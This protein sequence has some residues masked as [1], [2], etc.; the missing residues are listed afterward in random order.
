LA[1]HPDVPLR[2]PKS[3]FPVGQ[4]P[5]FVPISECAEIRLR[6]SASPFCCLFSAAALSAGYFANFS[7]ISDF[8][9]NPEVGSGIPKLALAA[10]QLPRF[11]AIAAAFLRSQKPDFAS[12]FRCYVARL[13][14]PFFLRDI[15]PIFCGF[16]ISRKTSSRFQA[17]PEIGLPLRPVTAI[18]P[19]FGSGPEGAIIRL[20]E[21]VSLLVFGIRSFCWVRRQFFADFG[22][23]AKRP[24]LAAPIGFR[25]LPFPVAQLPRIGPISATFR[26]T[27]K[28]DFAKPFRRFFRGPGRRSFYKEFRQ[29]CADF[30]L[31]AKHP[32]FPFLRVTSPIFR[33]F[34]ISRKTP[35]RSVFPGFPKL[36]FAVAQLPRFGPISASFPRSPKPGFARTFRRFFARFQQPFVMRD[37]LPF[38]RGFRISCEHPDA[39]SGRPPAHPPVEGAT[40]GCEAIYGWEPP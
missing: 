31:F 23:F 3:A 5:R 38:S 40:L 24:T 25:E 27:L 19:N 10:A 26:R 1:K 4:L 22:F 37:I 29:F 12:P 33:G 7:L 39:T 2:I 21:A 6:E 17:A 11:G 34:R 20:R 36:A 8:S 9:E 15:S 35:R 18:W 28:S 30:G 32:R 14:Q 16:R 13:R